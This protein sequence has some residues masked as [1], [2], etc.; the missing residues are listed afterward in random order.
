MPT[1]S[2]TL[3]K[4]SLALQYE[5]IPP[6]VIER[7]RSCMIDT[8]GAAYF[9][10]RFPWSRMVLDYAR[11]NGAPGDAQ[12]IGAKLRLRPPFAAMVNGVSLLVDGGFRAM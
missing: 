9:G 6:E 11:M 2:Q 12:V 4:F 1:A 3:A 8:I 7:A 10:A 5:Q